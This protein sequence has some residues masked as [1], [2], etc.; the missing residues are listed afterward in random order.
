[1][2][3]FITAEKKTF[4][5]RWLLRRLKVYPNAYYN[6]LKKRTLKTNQQK[7]AI[8]E[9]IKE[10]YHKQNGVPGYRMMKKLLERENIFISMT[11]AHYYMNKEC[12]LFSVVRKKRR[13]GSEKPHKVFDNLLN[14]DFFVKEPNL[15]WCTDFTYLLLQNGNKRYNCTIL[16]LY[17]RSVVASVTGKN[18]TSELAILALK[19]ALSNNP[20]ARRKGVVLHSDQGSQFTSKAF[21]QCCESHGVRQSMSRAGCPYDNAPIERYFNT[22]KSE[23][24]NLYSF[25]SGEKL[26]KAVSDFAYV[27]YNHGRPHSYNNWQTP[28]EKRKYTSN[29]HYQSV[30]AAKAA[31]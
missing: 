25:T 21:T 18:I 26:C 13:T 7:Q 14:Q 31:L 28:M 6:Y 11:T 17:D 9:K 19:K 16:D 3:D 20:S 1:V 27:W 2:Y 8:K 12:K 29:Y 24:I 5:L 22:L 15:R 10:I 30:Y 4:G 23:L